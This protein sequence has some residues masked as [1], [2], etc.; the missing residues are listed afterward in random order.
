[1]IALILCGCTT[2]RLEQPRSSARLDKSATY[3]IIASYWPSTRAAQ[4][5]DIVAAEIR[6]AGAKAIKL[7]DYV[8]SSWYN[9]VANDP[10]WAKEAAALKFDFVLC[11]AFPP[12][13]EVQD[14]TPTYIETLGSYKKVNPLYNA[15]STKNRSGYFVADPE[16]KLQATLIQAKPLQIVWTSRVLTSEEV[17]GH[18]PEFNSKVA[19]LILQTLLGQ[20]T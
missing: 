8:H 13:G 12:V 17:K 10:C 6:R 16:Y 2:L 11:L 20:S 15:K 4:A 14:Y 18:E 19:K 1:M 7:S 3:L 5:E 9:N